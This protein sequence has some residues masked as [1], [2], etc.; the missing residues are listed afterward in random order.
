MKRQR[1]TRGKFSSLVTFAFKTKNRFMRTLY[2][3]QSTELFLNIIDFLQKTKQ[4]FTYLFLC[5]YDYVTN[6]AIKKLSIYIH[7]KQLI[8][9]E[10]YIGAF[11]NNDNQFR[12]SIKLHKNILIANQFKLMLIIKAKRDS[13]NH[14][15]RNNPIKYFVKTAP[16]FSICLLEQLRSVNSIV[17][18]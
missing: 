7:R 12:V 6:M 11:I 15:L 9:S 16:A 14:N 3:Q 8:G 17:L 4:Y 18:Y 13:H 2:S 5:I 1:K 10:W